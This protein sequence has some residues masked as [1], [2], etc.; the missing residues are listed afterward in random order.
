MATPSTAERLHFRRTQWKL[1]IADDFQEAE[2]QTRG[3][4]RNASPA[5]RLTAL[6]NLREPFYGPDQTG[7]RL[8]RFLELVPIPWR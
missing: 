3:Y 6:E 7:G 4:W 2:S 8:Q 5:E 1:E